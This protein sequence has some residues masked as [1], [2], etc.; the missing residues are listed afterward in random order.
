MILLISP[1]QTSDT[2]IQTLHGLF[3]AGLQHFH[4]RK[5]EATLEDH[6]VYLDQIDPAYY[7]YIMT[8]NFPQELTQE[9]AIQGIHLEE[10]KWRAQGDQLGR[11][12]KSF[13]DRGFAVS[14]SYHES[15]DLAA[16]P[17]AFAYHLLSPVFAAISKS[18]MQGRG[19]DVR[20]IP[21]FI[22]GMGGINAHTTPEAVRLGFQG[23]GALG[24]V[25]N[26]SDPVRAFM[27]MQTAFAKAN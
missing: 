16:Q 3:E 13:T 6:R 11:Y 22:A 26:A 9:Y 7:K 21:K 23:V 5:P 27:E 20:H 18:D 8:H 14:S 17:V 10:R 1:E 24:G 4:F 2:E 12:V 19:F 15:E 25:W